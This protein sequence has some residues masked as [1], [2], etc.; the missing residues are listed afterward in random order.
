M[1]RNTI[2]V[3]LAGLGA[4]AAVANAQAIL[5]FGFTD[6]N[7]SFAVSD[8]SFTGV[9]DAATSGDVTRLASPGGTAVFAPG[10]VGTG[11]A[12]FSFD[13]DVMI[14]GAG[15]ASGTGTF[16][17]VD[18]HGERLT[19]DIDGNFT[20]LAPGVIAFNGLLANVRFNDVSGDGTFDGPSAGSF[21]T[22]LPGSAPFSGALVQL[23]ID[24]AGGFFDA[25]FTGVSTQVSGAVVPAPAS[26]ALLG[27]GGLLAARRRR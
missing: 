9:A 4:S 23:F 3:A 27:M 19:G 6:V 16:T 14:T 13:I 5:T 18:V 15:T 10:F 20:Q 21:G 24:G 17:I 2:L 22:D 1:G 11:A 7:G 26:L 12:D 25:D 8:G